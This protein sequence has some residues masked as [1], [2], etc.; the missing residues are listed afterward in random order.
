MPIITR[1]SNLLVVLFQHS[2]SPLFVLQSTDLS[3]SSNFVSSYLL[4]LLKQC[5]LNLERF[6][7]KRRFSVSEKY[8]Y[9]ISLLLAI[10]TFSKELADAVYL[11][12]DVLNHAC[13]S[14]LSAS[15]ESE[16]SW[17]V[18]GEEE[19]WNVLL[20]VGV[21]LFFAR[22]AQTR[23]VLARLFEHTLHT[24]QS[25]NSPVSSSSSSTRPQQLPTQ[26]DA[27]AD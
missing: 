14:E 23:P 5:I 12:E 16:R 10:D 2:N 18:T 6:L 1:D 19:L 20:R 24:L 4:P 22:P 25:V 17:W 8:A 11:Y 13:E 3:R 21:R 27:R 15:C 26:S 9:E 7:D